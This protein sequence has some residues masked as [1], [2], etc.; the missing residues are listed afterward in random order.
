MPSSSEAVATT[1]R[2]LPLLSRSS[3]DKRICRERLP[4][5]AATT[6]APR[7]TSRSSRECDTRSARRLVLTNQV[8]DSI[9]D[10]GPDRIRGHS[11]ELV[12]RYLHGQI[13]LALVSHVDDRWH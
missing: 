2:V 5:C 12:L 11:A 9:I 1:T 4:W 10:L 7:S 3:A 8:G 6:S 13:H